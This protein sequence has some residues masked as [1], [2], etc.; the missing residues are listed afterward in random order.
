MTV[1]QPPLPAD[2]DPVSPIRPHGNS[3]WEATEHWLDRASEILN[4]ILVKESRQ[5]L[6]SRQFAITFCLLL[7]LGWGWSLLGV[8]LASPTIY[9]APGGAGM[10]IGYFYVLAFPLIV[11]VPFSAYRSLA[12]EREDGT[13]ELLSITSLSPRQIIGG[14]LG[15]AIV[16]ML[17]YLSALSPCLAFTYLL[18]GIDILTIVLL[19]SYTVLA[20]VMA[21]ML[22]LLIATTSRNRH[23]Q[24]LFS[25]LLIVG[26]M[27][28]F[29]TVCIWGST[30][31]YRASLGF[32]ESEFWIAQFVFLSFYVT[33]IALFYLAA[34]ARISAPSEN[35]SSRLR[36]CMLIQHLLLIGWFFY[37]FVRFA[38]AD[39]FFGLLSIDLLY[40]Y[41]MG[42]LM[43]AE[44]AQLSQ[45]VK[46]GLP[47][48]FF[49][50]ALLTWFNPGPGTG[51]MYAAINGLSVAVLVLFALAVAEWFGFENFDEDVAWFAVVGWCY[52]AIYLGVIH[53]FI[54]TIRRTTRCTMLAGALMH[55]M[56]ILMGVIVPLILQL[57]I[58]YDDNYTPLQITNP[59]WTS[60]EAGGDALEYSI[61]ALPF[62]PLIPVML[63]GAATLIMCANTL[64]VA[65]EV[66]HVHE[67]A[68]GRV[69]EDDLALHPA[70]EVTP[71]RT[72]PWDET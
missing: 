7:V 42:I 30:A 60:V 28:A 46:R 57:S 41:L 65:T 9:Y 61:P 35:R 56:A 21:S 34:A 17:V 40:W 4:P 11:I 6:K 50:R 69:K 24:V 53:L 5:S 66:R 39:L 29:V 52:L 72:N 18:R 19:I 67:D 70:P 54:R 25:V 20:S 12:S 16:Q 59:F 14:K 22:A 48:S 68:P 51:Y 31:A 45:R 8:A 43:T 63:M 2:Q 71:T 38:D 1:A 58:L 49:G 32:D 10:L 23:L 36:W 27:I 26:L 15:S 44:S 13:Y 3:W 55:L 62:L 33:T 47:Q 64:V 37:Y